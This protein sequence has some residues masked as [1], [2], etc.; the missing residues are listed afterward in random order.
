MHAGAV[1]MHSFNRRGINWNRFEC[2]LDLYFDDVMLSV[3]VNLVKC[4]TY[5]VSTIRAYTNKGVCFHAN[6]L[7]V[8]M[9]ETSLALKVLFKPHWWCF[10]SLSKF[11]THFHSTR[12]PKPAEKK[13]IEL[14]ET[15]LH[16]IFDRQSFYFYIIIVISTKFYVV[17]RQLHSV[18]LFQLDYTLHFAVAAIKTDSRFTLHMQ[19]L[20]QQQ[21]FL[22]VPIKWSALYFVEFNTKSIFF[23]EYIGFG[24]GC[25]CCPNFNHEDFLNDKTPTNKTKL[26]T[27]G[28]TFLVHEHLFV[29]RLKI[30]NQVS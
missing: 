13:I 22:H 23:A 6:R 29:V 2:L 27:I 7:I 11:N 30:S 21:C 28:V 9:A 5:I 3:V 16:V 24:F 10:F 15:F 12:T 1:S 4:Y 25:D 17:R 20:Y 14:N 8:I 26:K 19:L 18:G